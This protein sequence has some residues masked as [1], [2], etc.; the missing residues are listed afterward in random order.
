MEVQFGIKSPESILKSSV[1]EVVTDKTYQGNQAVPGG[2][3]DARFGVIENGKVCPTCK[4]TNQHCPGHHG[5]IRLARPVYLYQFFDVIEKL[6]NTI[7]LNC[8]GILAPQGVLDSLTSTGIARFNEIR[9]N[10]IKLRKAGEETPCPYC[11]TPI[12]KKVKSVVGKALVLEGIPTTVPDEEE[13]GGTGAV[14]LQPEVVLRAFQRITDEDCRKLGFDPIHA[15]PEWMIC[16]VLFVPPLTVRPSV[17]MDDQQRMEDDLT[18]KLIDILRSNQRVRDKID[19]GANAETID[20]YTTHLQYDVA[21]YVD[22]D[23]KGMAPSQQRNGRPLR[24]LKSRF[25]SKT[26]RVRGNLMGKRVDFSARSVI[27]PDANIDLDELGVPEE[28]AMN[29]TFPEIVS[30]YNRERLMT[31]VRNGPDKHPGAKSVYVKR[32][33]ATFRL[34]YV[35]PETIELRE[36]DVVHRHLIDGDIV[37][38]NRQPSLHKASMEAHR[39]RVLP[40]STFRLNV[41]GCR[42]YNAD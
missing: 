14:P 4:Q 40:Y 2:V 16:T 6:C 23:I 33:K 27:T 24:T 28:I 1:V 7:C 5:H 21:T 11:E 39:V 17:V 12:F 20:K 18:H 15:R 29:L 10:R 37:L 8:S 26:G 9:A 31:Y 22:N 32:D 13:E 19:A 30:L 34:N 35:N 36:G 3:F 25:G 38:F 42:P 41:S